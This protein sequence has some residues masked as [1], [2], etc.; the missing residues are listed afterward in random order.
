MPLISGRSEQTLKEAAVLGQE[1]S[2]HEPWFSERQ[3]T[4]QVQDLP[5][6]RVRLNRD[7]DMDSWRPWT[8]GAGSREL[9]RCDPGRLARSRLMARFC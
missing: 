1:P 4:G 8:G 5:R 2:S 9:S 6:A 3:Q 7:G